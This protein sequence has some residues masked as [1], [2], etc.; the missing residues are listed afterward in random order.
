MVPRLR[1]DTF[2][3]PKGKERTLFMVPR[4]RGGHFLSP[5]R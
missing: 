3:G 4:V 1:S 2:Y 5:Q